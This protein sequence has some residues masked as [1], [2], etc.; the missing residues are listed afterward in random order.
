MPNVYLPRCIIQSYQEGPGALKRRKGGDTNLATHLHLELGT[1]PSSF[2][3]AQ[4]CQDFLCKTYP[5]SAY[6]R[7]S[8]NL[9]KMILLQEVLDNPSDLLHHN[10]RPISNNMMP[11]VLQPRI[12]SL[13]AQ[14]KLCLLQSLI[15]C[16]P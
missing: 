15:F 3:Q 2:H 4:H 13:R 6:K 10:P 16:R 12:T 1:P 9:S 11:T 5:C 14:L 8:L 7:A